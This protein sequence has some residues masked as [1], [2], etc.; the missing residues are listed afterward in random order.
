MQYLG[1]K[2]THSLGKKIADT[3]APKGLWFE[4]FAGGL[5][6]SVELAR[7]GP[8]I[9]MDIHPGLIALYQACM[10]GYVPP[11]N[12][13]KEEYHAAKALP[14][15]DPLK[16]FIGFACSFGGKWFGGY[17]KDNPSKH[18]QVPHG[19]LGDRLMVGRRVLAPLI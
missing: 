19:S 6:V 3:I 13:T 17:A 9:V 11:L 7:Y 18:I 16:A 4:A 12:V 10:L 1:G 14:D 15:S 8:G 2:R 5:S